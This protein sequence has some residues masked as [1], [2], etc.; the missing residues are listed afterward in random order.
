MFSL[1]R[2]FSPESLEL[3]YQAD[4]CRRFAVQRRAVLFLGALIWLALQPRETRA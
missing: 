1:P 2:Q 3:A 4:H